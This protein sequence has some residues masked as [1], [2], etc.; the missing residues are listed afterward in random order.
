MRQLQVVVCNHRRNRR[1]VI[2]Q[3]TRQ[4]SDL[5]PL[6]GSNSVA[7]SAR[8]GP[9]PN[10]PV[11]PPCTHFARLIPACPYAP[12]LRSTCP[13][14][15][16]QPLEFIATTSPPTGALRRATSLL[17]DSP[18]PDGISQYQI[19]PVVISGHCLRKRGPSRHWVCAGRPPKI[20]LYLL[21]L[22]QVYSAAV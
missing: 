13:P 20:R 18:S 8:T 16:P 12:S 19:S 4:R 2:S 5:S 11:D 9:H 17:A 15:A 22:V 10:A 1:G 14:P 21:T 7:V 6:R 3:Q